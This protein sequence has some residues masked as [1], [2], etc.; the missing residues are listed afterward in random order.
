MR[1]IAWSTLMALG[2]VLG[3]MSTAYAGET[4]GRGD[5]IPGADNAASE[6]AFSGRDLP[7]SVEN[8]P[9]G[10]DDDAITIHGVQSY[11]QFVSQGLKAFV[12]SPGDAC[13]GNLG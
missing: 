10:Y 9:P 1:R 4:N 13:R 8:N 6:C 12:P 3:G 5:P 2:L 11:G 7:D